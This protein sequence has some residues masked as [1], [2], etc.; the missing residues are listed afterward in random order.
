MESSRKSG[1][2]LNLNS[3]IYLVEPEPALPARQPRHFCIISEP[4][5][6]LYLAAEIRKHPLELILRRL[7]LD[8]SIRSQE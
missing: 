5:E 2:D 7:L 1:Y 4:P 3:L 8:L 6:P